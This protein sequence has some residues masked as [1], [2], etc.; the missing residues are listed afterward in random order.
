[1]SKKI[2]LWVNK[3]YINDFINRYRSGSVVGV[4]FPIEFLSVLPVVAHLRLAIELSFRSQ[5]FYRLPLR[6]FRFILFVE[7]P[8][9]VCGV[10]LAHSFF[11]TRYNTVLTP[12]TPCFRP[13]FHLATWKL[14]LVGFREAFKKVCDSGIAHVIDHLLSVWSILVVILVLFHNFF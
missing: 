1:M 8:W 11:T 5:L 10:T 7:L 3:V 13:L 6:P 12:Q 4:P 14:M 9:G 2:I